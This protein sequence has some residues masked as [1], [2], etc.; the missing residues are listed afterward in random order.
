MQLTSQ[1]TT[2]AAPYG[3]QIVPTRPTHRDRAPRPYTP[4]VA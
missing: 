3:S 4:E 1:M 2:W